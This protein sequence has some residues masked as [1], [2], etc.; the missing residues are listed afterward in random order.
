MMLETIANIRVLRLTTIVRAEFSFEPSF[1]KLGSFVFLTSGGFT[2]LWT[3]S[4]GSL[5]R[6]LELV[7][8]FICCWIFF[9][10][11]CMG[12]CCCFICCHLAQVLA[13]GVASFVLPPLPT[14][15]QRLQIVTSVGGMPRKKKSLKKLADGGTVANGDG[16]RPQ[17]A[18]AALQKITFGGAVSKNPKC[19]FWRFQHINN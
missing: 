5:E 2:G 14:R 19:A 16:S 1:I 6:C 13:P 17:R 12:I 8:Y 15:T 3:P 9:L 18:L 4:G 7:V 11:L 10:Y